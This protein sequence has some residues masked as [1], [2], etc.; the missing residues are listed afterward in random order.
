M[1]GELTQHISPKRWFLLLIVFCSLFLSDL[2]AQHP[3]HYSQYLFNQ[4]VLNPAYAGSH[5]VLRVSALFRKQ[6]IDL[7]GAPQVFTFSADTRIGKGHNNVGVYYVNDRLGKMHRNILSGMYA[8]RFGVLKGKL[9]FGLQAG[10][11]LRKQKNFEVFTVQN[12][13]ISFGE[14]ARTWAIPQFGFG[15]WYQHP[16]FFIGFSVPELLRIKSG[17]YQTQFANE[18]DFPHFNL[19][20]GLL[21][22]L[23]RFL[24]L[25][26]TLLFKFMQSVKTQVDVSAHLIIRDQF[27]VGVSYRS[28]DAVVFLFQAQANKQLRL[29][30]SYDLST[31]GFGTLNLGSHGLYATYEF[32]YHLKTEYPRLF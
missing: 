1:K 23:N 25:K 7:P 31:Q 21:F 11:E 29:G 9:S 13:D 26:P 27:W 2:Q 32:G 15:A 3:A 17:K 18:V 10:L 14:T 4:L 30:Y 8:Y 24:K 5:D 20:S 16:R 19:S 28:E 12:P 6:W 22:N